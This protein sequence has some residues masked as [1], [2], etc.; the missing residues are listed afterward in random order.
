MLQAQFFFG[1]RA[2]FSQVLLGVRAGAARQ[3]FQKTDHLFRTLRHL[4]HQRHFRVVA[5]AEQDGFL[6]AQLEQIDDIGAVVPILFLAE[7]GAQFGRLGD[8]GVV[9]LFTQLTVVGKL[10][11]RVKG[12]EVQ[13]EL[14]AFFAVLFPRCCARPV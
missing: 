10:Q 7:A 12:G 2:Q 6:M 8:V 9:D 1:K 4:R 5:V 13:R 11:D 3:V 14:V